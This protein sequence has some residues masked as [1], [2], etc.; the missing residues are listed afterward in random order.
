MLRLLV[1]RGEGSQ[2][3]VRAFDVTVSDVDVLLELK[4][5]GKVGCTDKLRSLNAWLRYRQDET[6]VTVGVTDLTVHDTTPSGKNCFLSLTTPRSLVSIAY[7]STVAVDLNCVGSVHLGSFRT[8]AA[9]HLSRRPR[10]YS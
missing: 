8:Q 3:V 4:P 9:L 1:P 10:N 6:V 2:A 5:E 7:A